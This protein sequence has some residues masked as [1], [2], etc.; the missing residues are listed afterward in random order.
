[1]P[2]KR[3]TKG[4]KKPKKM[5]LESAIKLIDEQANYVGLRLPCFWDL[6]RDVQRIIERQMVEQDNHPFKEQWYLQEQLRENLLS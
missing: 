4:R 2:K 6:T 5:S 1:M 3:V